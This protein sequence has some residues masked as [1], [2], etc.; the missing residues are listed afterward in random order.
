[1]AGGAGMVCTIR[2]P[3]EIVYGVSIELVYVCCQEGDGV[4]CLTRWGAD[5]RMP[6]MSEAVCGQT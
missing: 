2:H 3:L 1:M 4:F 5:A 6:E